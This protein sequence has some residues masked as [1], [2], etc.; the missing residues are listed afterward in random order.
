MK[1]SLVVLEIF[2]KMFYF[3]MEVQP[4]FIWTIKR[5]GFINLG[6]LLLQF[7]SVHVV[8]TFCHPGAMGRRSELF[9]YQV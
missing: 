1:I 4:R 3:G 9:L 2:G 8:L 7:D 6:S 5:L